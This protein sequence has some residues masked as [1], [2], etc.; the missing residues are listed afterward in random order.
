MTQADRSSIDLYWLPLGAGGHSVRWNG[1]LYE[2]FAARR[3][4]RRPQDLYHSALEV[5]HDGG[6]YTIEMG[7]AWNVASPS[8]GVV[9]VGAVG[10]GWLGRFWMFR[11]EVRCWR[12]GQIPDLAEAV[13]SPQRVSNDAGQVS[14][15]LDATRE[16]PPLAWGRDEIGC[17]E[18]WN[19]N[20][21]TSWLLARTGHD[22]SAI[23][24]PAGGRAPGWSAGLV[25][26]CREAE[27]ISRAQVLPAETTSD[28]AGECEDGGR[29]TWSTAGRSARPSP[30]VR[31]VR[32]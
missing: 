17:G 10:A 31:E 16:V 19:S 7:P 20:S 14:D 32:A 5:R 1:R 4:H 13:G 12:G 25:L 24:P 21:L 6:R 29:G 9:C 30:A 27:A 3:E 18:M 28:R 22:M 11:Y 26:A 15:L 8:R 23:R 2:A